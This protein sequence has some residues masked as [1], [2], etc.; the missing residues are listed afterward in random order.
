[1]SDPGRLEITL[2][3]KNIVA[4]DLDVGMLLLRNSPHEDMNLTRILRKKR[5]NLLTNERVG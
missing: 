3:N 2:E 4:R 5:R 1:M